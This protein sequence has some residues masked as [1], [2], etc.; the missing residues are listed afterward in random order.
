MLTH[1]TA[2]SGTFDIALALLPWQIIWQT[3]LRKREKLGALIAMSM[4]VLYAS[5]NMI[6]VIT[7]LNPS[8]ALA[9]SPF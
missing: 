6:P 5:L 4:G 3:S 8:P 2:F 1:V 9:S 7:L